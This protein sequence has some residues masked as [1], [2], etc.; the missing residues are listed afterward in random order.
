MTFCMNVIS[1]HL[2]ISDVEHLPFTSKPSKLGLSSALIQWCSIF[3]HSM[4]AQ[5]QICLLLSHPQ[6]T[7]VVPWNVSP[8]YELSTKH[9]THLDIHSLGSSSFSSL[10]GQFQSFESTLGEGIRRS[11]SC[12]IQ[13]QSKTWLHLGRRSKIWRNININF[14]WFSKFQKPRTLPN[15]KGWSIF[16]RAVAFSFK[17]WVIKNG[18]CYM[19]IKF[20]IRDYI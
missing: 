13:S 5:L 6:I 7:V 18:R 9:I 8:I 19:Y 17:Q 11:S 4:H 14:N 1:S 2:F 15:S 10:I 3:D 20:Y 16:K 12:R